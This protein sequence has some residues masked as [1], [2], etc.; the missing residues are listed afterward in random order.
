MQGAAYLPEYVEVFGAMIAITTVFA[1]MVVG[2]LIYG[3]GEVIDLLQELVDK[4]KPKVEEE[5][6]IEIPK[7]PFY[8]ESEI[9]DYYKKK[10]SEIGAIKLTSKSDTFSVEVD[11]KIEYIE[12]TGFTP[13]VLTQEETEKLME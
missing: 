3:F 11:G 13:K 8:A 1:P 5:S 9:K 7:V 10:N 4:G 12:L 6:L 2:L